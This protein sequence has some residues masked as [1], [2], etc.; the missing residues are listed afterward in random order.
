[1]QPEL[2][3][4]YEGDVWRVKILQTELEALGIDTFVPD[5]YVPS[6]DAHLSGLPTWTAPLYVRRADLERARR[7]IEK[8]PGLD[9]A[10]K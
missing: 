4:A 9:E 8:K 5:A 7:V 1:V 3:L 6:Q 10:K 2:A